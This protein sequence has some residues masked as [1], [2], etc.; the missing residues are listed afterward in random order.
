[1]DVLTYNQKAHS[2]RN[3]P[4]ATNNAVRWTTAP[5]V[6]P[7][8]A[9]SSGLLTPGNGV[10]HSGLGLSTPIGN[11]DNAPPDMPTGL[12]DL[13]HRG[14]GSKSAAA[15]VWG[16]TD[17]QHHTP[18]PQEPSMCEN[19]HQMVLFPHCGEAVCRVCGSCTPGPSCFLCCVAGP[20]KR[21]TLPAQSLI[22]PR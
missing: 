4:E 6:Q 9:N 7:A 19:P 21:P 15:M 3:A 10:A 2:Q 14:S 5:S 12:F 17:S 18:A 1:M 11:Q 16:R 20:T 13:N 22:H 8:S